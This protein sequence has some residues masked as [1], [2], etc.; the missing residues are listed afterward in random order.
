M[1]SSGANVDINANADV[2]LVCSAAQM[3]IIETALKRSGYRM[4][5][6]L[7]R[8]DFDYRAWTCGLALDIPQLFERKQRF[9]STPAQDPLDVLIRLF[10]L[11]DVVPVREV[12]P[13]FQRD[14]LR[15]LEASHLCRPGPG[16]DELVCPFGFYE[17]GGLFVV[18]DRELLP[19]AGVSRIMPMLP[20]SYEFATATVRQRGARVLDMGTGSGVH[21][22]LAS[23]HAESVIGVD[24]NP[25][26]V[27]FAR[28]NKALNHADRVEFVL[29]DMYADLDAR[30][31]DL[32]IFCPP[33][34]PTETLGTHPL[35]ASGGP[36]GDAV[37]SRLLAGLADHLA[38]GGFC[39]FCTLMT[40]WDDERFEHRIFRAVGDIEQF[41]FVVLGNPI[42]FRPRRAQS[43][44]DEFGWLQLD[45]FKRAYK[46]YGVLTI[47]HGAGARSR[48]VHAPFVPP[49][50]YKVEQLF[51]IMQTATASS[52]L[53]S[54]LGAETMIADARSELPPRARA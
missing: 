21:A 39:Q 19:R 33:N 36:G 18:T 22:L 20:E 6:I 41:D 1:A 43:E 8:I 47:R 28:F 30:K 26:A 23:Q 25:R 7:R 52:T 45:S 16:A 37:S 42:E 40:D 32:I 29:G 50:T 51:Q 15:A 53:T 49:L 48:Y 34:G 4:T 31:F 13:I 12:E 11:G 46:E 35:E 44:R 54:M 5:E 3:S 24:I 10:F 9:V 38:D 14:G 27:E 17:I 2:P